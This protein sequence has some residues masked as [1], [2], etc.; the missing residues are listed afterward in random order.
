M[1]IYIVLET[2]TLLIIL[3]QVWKFSGAQDGRCTYAH[4]ILVPG[5]HVS[6]LLLL[7]CLELSIFPLSLQPWQLFLA[8]FDRVERLY[9]QLREGCSLSEFRL[10]MNGRILLI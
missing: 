9:R 1:Q 4:L 7:T 2:E 5:L 3:R 6:G 10:H 8:K